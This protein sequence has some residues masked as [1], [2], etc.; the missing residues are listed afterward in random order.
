MGMIIGM[1]T[2]MLTATQEVIVLLRSPGQ[3]PQDVCRS[4]RVQ[5]GGLG[6]CLDQPQGLDDNQPS[7]AG[8]G[9]AVTCERKCNRCN[10]E[11]LTA[12]CSLAVT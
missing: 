3:R 10:G 5:P 11:G 2:G 7:V 1:L 4:W 8:P 12:R 6:G 9:S